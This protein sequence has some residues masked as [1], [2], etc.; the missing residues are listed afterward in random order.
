[1]RGARSDEIAT[2][3]TREKAMRYLTVIKLLKALEV[4]IGLDWD[5]ALM[6][7][8]PVVVSGATLEGLIE[9]HAEQI[10]RELG[11]AGRRAMECF[12]GGPLNGQRH[13]ALFAVGAHRGY[14]QGPKKWAVYQFER[15]GRAFFRGWATSQKKAW[16]G[17]VISEEGSK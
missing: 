4:E 14:R 12:V 13:D 6:F 15:D 17:E 9:E 11:A 10:A 7:T 16:R 8:C 3:S 2:W 1:M 5:G